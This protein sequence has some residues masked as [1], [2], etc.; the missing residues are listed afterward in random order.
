MTEQNKQADFKELKLTL[1]KS[2]S[3]RLRK[4]QATIKCLGLKKINQSVKIKT[5][6]VIMG[7]VNSVSYLLNIEEVN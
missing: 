4:H 3:G 5:N 6:P 7:M 2:L 1:V